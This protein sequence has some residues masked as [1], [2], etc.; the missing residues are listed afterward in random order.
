LGVPPNTNAGS[1]DVFVT[2]IAP[3]GSSLV[4]ST[5]V[6][7]SGD[8]SGNAIAVDK[9]TGVA[10]VAG[11]TKSTDF[12][13]TLGAFQPALGSGATGNAFVFELG[14]GGATLIYS[15]YLGGN[16]D[17]LALGVALD[18]AVPPNAYAVGSTSST[19][20]P[21]KNALQSSVGGGFVTK[22]NSSGS[23]LVYST[24][25]GGSGDSVNAVAVAPASPNNAY[26]TGATT[27]ASFHTTTGAFQTTYGGISDAFVTVITPAGA[28]AYSTFLGGSGFDT[29]N[30][31]A[32]DSSGNAYVTG[33]TQSSTDFHTT[34]GALQT[35]FGG[36][37]SDAFVTKLSPSGT[38]VSDLVYSTFLGGEL[39]DFGA[40]IAVDGSNNAYV[41][42]QTNSTSFPMVTPTQS[43]LGGGNDAFVS[44]INPAGSQLVFS[45]YLGG[46]ADEDDGGKSGAIAVD[47]AGANIY[48][49]GN[50]ASTDFR[51]QGTPPY[52]GGNAN[53]GS[54]DAFVVK[55]AQSSAASTFS[56]S[57][58]PLS[59]S[60]VNPGGSATSTVTVTPPNGFNGSVTITCAISPT[61]SLGPACGAVSATST[62]P[63]TLTVS[64]TAASALLRHPANGRFSGLFYALFLPIGGVALIGLGLGSAGLPRKKLFGFL[65]VGLLL[66]GLILMPACG[67]GSG[68][69]GGGG[70]TGT[71]AGT[72]TITVS[73]TATGATQTGTS[74]ALTLIVN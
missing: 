61:V 24:Y 58:T 57:A 49:T 3:D 36:G 42:G 32:V 38:G 53:A 66:S 26:V 34:T 50:T 35:T 15:T 46:S 6:G 60:M 29:G 23:A 18:S 51:T 74:P 47:S 20:F 17:D 62:A 48:V 30:G 45:T 14:A 33:E 40:S 43:A 25:L 27:S 4:Y 41:T 11:G 68:G 52:T 31:I 54:N 19:N 16:G 71:P 12:P 8:D 59:P 28:Y 13:T 2:E 56:L 39:A 37:T 65:L 63:A 22:L 1:F 5:Y 72:Y 67:G 10:F 55:Y 73:G 69:G 44:E 64:T 7:G 9:T 21:L 70:G